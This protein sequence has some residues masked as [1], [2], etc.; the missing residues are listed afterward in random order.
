MQVSVSFV[1]S[2]FLIFC[3]S[4]IF[5]QMV[6]KVIEARMAVRRQDQLL[7]AAYSKIIRLILQGI[8]DV[9]SLKEVVRRE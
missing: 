3:V 9:K 6:W 1:V 4:W 8:Q 2:I 5:T 7:D